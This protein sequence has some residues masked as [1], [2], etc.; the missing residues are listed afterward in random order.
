M[1]VAHRDVLPTASGR[2]TR[3][4]ALTLLGRRRAM[5]L[6]VV[7]VF[8]A[9]TVAT[10]AS[11]P[12]FGRLVDHVANGDSYR[13]VVAI[14]AAVF[15]TGMAG[16]LLTALGVGLMGRTVEGGLAQLREDVVDHVLAAPLDRLE[17]AGIGDVAARVGADVEAV[18]ALATEALPV[19]LSSALTVVLGLAGMAVLD[20]RLGLAGLLAAPIQVRALWWY[21][22]RSRPVYQR[23][24]VVEGEL[25]EQLLTSLSGAP[26]VRAYRM[27]PRRIAHIDGVAAEVA[28]LWMRGTV[29]ST[30][31]YGRLNIAEF[32][33]TSAVLATGFYLVQHDVITIGA[34]SAGALYFV[35]LFNPINGLLGL[36]DDVQKA[37]AALAR[38]VG[39]A[40]MGSDGPA[41]P[42]D[43]AAERADAPALPAVEVRDVGFAYDGEHPVLHGVG[44]TVGRGERVAIVGR[45]GAG[46]STLA[47][48]IAGMHP[49]SAGDVLVD[50]TAVASVDADG[51]RP[52]VVLVSQETHVFDGSL[53]DDLR[54][55][56]PDATDDELRSALDLVGAMAW[57]EALPS[58]LDTEVGVHGHELSPTEAQQ[59]ALARVVLVD[60]PVVILDEATA[61]AGSAGARVLETAADRVLAGRTAIVIAHRLT[62]AMHADRIVVMDG[63]RVVESGSH[64]ELSVAGGRYAELWASWSASRP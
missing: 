11:A 36:F 18:S 40:R 59:L 50:G 25:A 1:I 2:E 14:A 56:R 8:V 47:K 43:G 27:G 46:K 42:T 61:E 3:R 15:G 6:A 63:G 62:Q 41:A 22:P 21:L 44:L 31:F 23:A 35:G 45:T 10:L 33:G 55:V 9:A 57:V 30:R 54:L 29:L 19:F 53:A 48:L 34:A 5:S 60:P 4:A 37:V 49:A 38:L 64:A 16:G 28:A 7:A 58:G 39:V 20:W 32:V 52:D 12:L 13:S 51:A 24:K 17:R 26:T